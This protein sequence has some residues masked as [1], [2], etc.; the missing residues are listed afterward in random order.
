MPEFTIVLGNKAYSSWSLRGWL[1]LKLTGAA[2]DEVVVP[3]YRPETKAAIRAHSPSG[4]VPTLKADGLAVWDT[5]AIAEYLHERFPE[6]GLWPEDPAARARARSVAAEMHAGFPTLRARLPMDLKRGPPEP[7]AGI[8][9]DGALAGEIARIVAIWSDC[10]ARFGAA[11]DFLFGRF[12]AAD[13]FYA[14]VATRFV[15]Y[16]VALEGG[17]ADYRDALMARPDLSDWIAAANA[18][19]WVIEE[20]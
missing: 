15:T 18:E 5:L 16:G 9:V 20:P 13:A 2:F 6:A 8:A 11:G 19:P 3:L 4:R 12:G 7:G 17:V 14:P 10:R 1:M